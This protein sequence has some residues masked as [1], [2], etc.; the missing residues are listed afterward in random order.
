[1][2]ARDSQALCA[3]HA[4]DAKFRWLGRSLCGKGGSKQVNR[5]H[6][7]FPIAPILPR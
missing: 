1:V 3:G 4:A 7:K 6:D 2:R 5:G